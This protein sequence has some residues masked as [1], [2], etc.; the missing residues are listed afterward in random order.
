MARRVLLTAAGRRLVD[1]A[2]D[3]YVE[4]RE[5]SAAVQAAYDRWSRAPHPRAV[6][7]EEY[8]AALER[9]DRASL[10]YALLV[11]ALA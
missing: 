8:T 6:A 11:A 9:E 3:A 2:M 1:D 5:L 7:F 10:R 4:W